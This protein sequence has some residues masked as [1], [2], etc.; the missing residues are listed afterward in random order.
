MHHEVTHVC[1]GN[2]N[3]RIMVAKSC[4]CFFLPNCCG[5]IQN[6]LSPLLLFLVRFMAK[7]KLLQK[8]YLSRQSH[9][10]SEQDTLF[11]RSV[12]GLNQSTF[13]DAFQVAIMYCMNVYTK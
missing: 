6:A 4:Y 8:T 2:S 11:Q 13:T 12:G 7:N 10:S 3:E 9:Y 1:G 5:W